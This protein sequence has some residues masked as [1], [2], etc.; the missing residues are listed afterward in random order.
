LSPAVDLNGAWSA[1]D[2]GT[3]Y[4]RQLGD[5]SVSW[6]GLEDSGFHRGIGFT[7]VFQGRISTDGTTLAG[8]WADVPRGATLNSGTLTLQ[9][10]S[11]GNPDI[12]VPVRLTS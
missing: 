7:N 1:D 5:G 12:L 4:I 6:A 3:Y 11:A 2:G 10:V 9:M 8:E